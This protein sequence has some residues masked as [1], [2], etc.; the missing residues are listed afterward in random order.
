MKSFKEFTEA[1]KTKEFDDFGYQIYKIQMKQ[2]DAKVKAASDAY[3]EFPVDGIMG[4]HSD[5]TKANPKY[6]EINRNFNIEFKKM[7][8]FNKATPKE[9]KRKASEERRAKQW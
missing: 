6:K 8:D 3:D 2:I 9:F 4:M 1:K 7:Q 5:E